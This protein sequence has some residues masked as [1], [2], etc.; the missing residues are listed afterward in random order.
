[1]SEQEWSFSYE[2]PLHE[3]FP[4]LHE[5]QSAYLAQIDSLDVLDRKTHELIRLAVAVLARNSG[6]IARHAQLAAE[7]GASWHEIVAAIVLTQPSFGLLPTAEA[8]PA[9]RQGYD[10]GRRTLE[11]ELEEQEERDA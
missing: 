6:G 8:L 11:E 5:A 2:G 3:V 1:M 9:A 10:T 4:A 7:V